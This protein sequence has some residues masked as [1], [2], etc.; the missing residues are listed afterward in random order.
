MNKYISRIC[1]AGVLASALTAN[2]QNKLQD[3]D[4]IKV[5]LGFGVEQ[6]L[7]VSSAAATI[8][9]SE[10]LKQTSAI[11]LP[12]ALYGRLLGLTALKTGGFSGDDNYGAWFNIRGEQT[13]SENG[14]LILVDGIKRPIDRLTVDE[15]E[16]VTKV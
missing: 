8:I 13:T 14:I 9:T 16:S 6:K 5:D 11:N 3:K 10:E 1:L 7:S 4:S 15:V 12:D 2:A